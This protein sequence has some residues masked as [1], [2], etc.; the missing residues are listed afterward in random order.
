MAQEAHLQP[1][2][3]VPAG[4]GQTQYSASRRVWRA[5]VQKSAQCRCAA[6]WGGAIGTD[7]R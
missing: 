6:A 2:V 7:R 4:K 5:L 1:N 3:C